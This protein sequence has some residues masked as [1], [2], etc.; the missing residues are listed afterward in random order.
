MQG[1]TKI[2]FCDRCG[3]EVANGVTT[4][5]FCGMPTENEV[6]YTQP[7]AYQGQTGQFLPDDLSKFGGPSPYQTGYTPVMPAMPHVV[8]GSQQTPRYG[9]PHYS[10]QSSQLPPQS[11]TQP[12][13][14]CHVV[15]IQNTSSDGPLIAELILSLFGVF[16]VGWL[17]GGETTVGVVLLLCSIFIYW[18][19][20][21]LGTFFTF[22][23]GLVCLGP[24]AIGGIILNALLCSSTLKRHAARTIVLQST[25]PPHVPMPPPMQRPR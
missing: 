19:V 14:Q 16:G 23:L 20:M 13:P 7:L 24:L 11:Y 3:N 18:P 21:I 8:Y 25:P 12:Y 2:M 17:M 4:C 5:P 22:G 1:D 15:V 6:Q 9:P 10:P